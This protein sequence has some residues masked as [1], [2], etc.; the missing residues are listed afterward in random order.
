[1]IGKYNPEQYKKFRETLPARRIR[2]TTLWVNDAFPLFRLKV[3]EE[4]PIGLFLTP[5]TS[6]VSEKN[7]GKKSVGQR[8][9][10]FIFGKDVFKE[11]REKNQ[12]VSLEVL[13]EHRRS[14]IISRAYFKDNEG[15]LYRDIDIKGIGYIIRDSFGEMRVANILRSGDMVYGLENRED[16]EKDR[17]LSEKFV[18]AGIRSTRVIAIIQPHEIII[19]SEG[20]TISISI[21]EA[22]ERGLIP[23]RYE[24]V[25][26]V[27]AFGVKTR[28]NEQMDQSKK[29]FFL[30]D[31]RRFV[32]LE[33]KRNEFSF[34]D[35]MEWFAETLGNNIGL[36]HSNGWAHGHFWPDYK[37]PSNV[38][39]DC[40]IV[41]LGTVIGR[42]PDP[43]LFIERSQEDLRE[44]EMII[45]QLYEDLEPYLHPKVELSFF[46]N[47]FLNTYRQVNQGGEVIP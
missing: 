16:A 35:Y 6:E 38:T 44:A 37:R 1:M 22:K 32:A 39:L 42:A 7:R 15:R 36:M 47:L 29:F 27:R 23:E 33:L 11:D 17:D 4:A 10:E 28:V 19:D 3:G 46:H 2:N 8:I 14:A 20:K 31:A 5:K 13:P 18:H 26:T 25:L 43:Q 30:D 40:R 41:D 21:N 9:W 45:R 34:K 12:T 24:P